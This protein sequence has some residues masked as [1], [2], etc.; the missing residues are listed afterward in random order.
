MYLFSEDAKLILLPKEI[1]KICTIFQSMLIQRT[2]IL[3]EGI[4]WH[5]P[6][7]K[8][9]SGEKKEELGQKF[10][11]SKNKIPTK[12]LMV[13]LKKFDYIRRHLMHITRLIKD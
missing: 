2:R 5:K 12:F 10:I 4:S 6:L 1:V 9:S 7:S 3:Y 11:T 13:F 8:T